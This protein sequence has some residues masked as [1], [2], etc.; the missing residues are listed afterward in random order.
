MT[1]QRFSDFLNMAGRIYYETHI[2]PLLRM[3]GSFNE[4]AIDMVAAS[5]RAGADDRQC[6]GRAATPRASRSLSGWP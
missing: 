6:A 1:G 3:Q 4:F 2:A 5:R